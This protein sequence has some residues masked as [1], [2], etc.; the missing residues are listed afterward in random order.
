MSDGRTLTAAELRR[1]RMTLAGLLT[2]AAPTRGPLSASRIN[3]AVTLLC[4]FYR[5]SSEEASAYVV[6]VLEAHAK[7]W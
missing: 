1:L 7:P 5:C 4:A 2:R 6:E 3:M